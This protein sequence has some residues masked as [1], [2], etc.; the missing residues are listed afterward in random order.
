M[1]RSR[2][3]KGVIQRF[4]DPGYREAIRL[5]QARIMPEAAEKFDFNG[6]AKS[7][8]R[9]RLGAGHIPRPAFR[10]WLTVGGFRSV[11][12]GAA[13]DG[14]YVGPVVNVAAAAEMTVDFDH[15]LFVQQGCA[16][17]PPQRFQ[18]LAG[19]VP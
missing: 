4:P 12:V 19:P 7:R 9:S 11:E 13:K 2:R 16:V 18:C 14:L 15:L 10:G 5:G 6:R 17:F 8:S 3:C 1:P